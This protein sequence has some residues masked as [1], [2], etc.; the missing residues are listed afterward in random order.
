MDSRRSVA[1]TTLLTDRAFRSSSDRRLASA[2]DHLLNHLG[3]PAGMGKFGG[4]QLKLASR[5]TR[6]SL[7]HA[8]VAGGVRTRMRKETQNVLVSASE[9]E[10]SRYLARRARDGVRV[11]LNLLGEAVLSEAEVERRMERYLT[12]LA[13]TDVST[14]SVKVSSIDCRVDPLAHEATVARIAPRLARLYRA[15]LEHRTADGSPKLVNLDMEA[16]AELPI[17]LALFRDVLGRP[18]FAELTAGVVLQA[19]LPDAF[20]AQQSLTEF[21]QTR[22]RAGGAPIR[23][24]IVKGANMAAEAVQSALHGLAMPTYAEK[25]QTDQNYRRMLSFAAHPEQTS[26]VLVGAASHNVFDLALALVLRA[27]HGVESRMGV[28][29]LEGMANPLQRAISEVCEDVLVYCPIVAPDEMQSAIAYLLRRLDENSAPDNFLRKGFAMAPGSEAL[30]RERAAFQEAYLARDTPSTTPLRTPRTVQASSPQMALEHFPNEPDTDFSLAA[31]R[32]AVDRHRQALLRAQPELRSLLDGPEREEL[33]GPAVDGFDPSRPDAIPYRMRLCTRAGVEQCIERA[34]RAEYDM[35]KAN[36]EARSSYLAR[37]AQ[38]LREHRAELT[39]TMVIDGGKRI[40]EADA[41]VSEAIDFAEYY[42]LSF[43]AAAR[44]ASVTCKGRGVTV[45]TPP[46]NFPL[47]IPAGGV[48]AALMAGNPVIL[49]PALETAWVAHLLVRLC[50]EAGVPKHA[51]QLCL[52]S[53]DVGQQ[54]IEDARVRQVVLTGGTATARL[55]TRL[56]PGLRLLAETGGKNAVIVSAMADRDQAIAD[57]IRSAFGHAGQK[58]SAASLLLCEAE[59]FDDTRFLAQLKEAV[60]SLP[61]GSAHDPQNVVTPLIRPPE[62]A[63]L[64]A[65]HAAHEG[66]QWLVRPQASAENPRLLSPGVL[67]DAPRGGFMH[68]T[69]LFG[70]VL[71]VMRATD[72]YDAIDIAN[73]TPYGLTAGLHSLDEREQQ[74]F[75]RRMQAGNLYINR[76]ITGAVVRRQPFGGWKASNY[77]PGAKAGG[78]NYVQ[79]L[80]EVEA[81]STPAVEAPPHPRAAHLLSRMRNGLGGADRMRLSS[82][83]CSYGDAFT[84]FFHDPEDPSAVIGEHN[85]LRYRALT[86]LVVRF[87]DPARSF[88]ALLSCLAA[89]TVGCDFV[90]SVPQALRERVEDLSDTKGLRLVVE[91]EADLRARLDDVRRVRFIGTPGA[92]LLQDAAGLGVHVDT[93]PA[94]LSGRFELPRYLK[95]QSVCV[96]FHCHGNLSPA[97]LQEAPEGL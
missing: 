37:A 40:V 21:A 25:Q 84:R 50:H 81:L 42:R 20:P 10:L 2:L 78:P 66:A 85:Y 97:L 1:F 89:S 15:A 96:A 69:E 86:R 11:N 59:V 36:L 3:A 18:E 26:A 52:C 7:A 83:A 23:L 22:V 39:A 4:A 80:C 55:F 75:I 82:A 27:C 73:E 29:L 91:S 58:C 95:E 43:S 41:E 8:A 92:S 70:P 46:W 45:V 31:E 17:T 32:E 61:V 72:L 30:T 51:L 56:R 24:R 88:E 60:Q 44:E 77:G 87:A 74:R 68:R 5:A 71:T 93:D 57:V 16:Y 67:I 90:L 53:D 54:L 14:I 47:A 19:Y 9:P 63:L 94:Q 6:L 79:Q 76:T 13:R 33:L 35:A 64:K 65:L 48:F 12:L 38:A 49:K 28:E 62:G 34:K